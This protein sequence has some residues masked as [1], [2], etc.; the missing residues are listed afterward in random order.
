MMD[1]SQGHEMKKQPVMSKHRTFLAKKK[2]QAWRSA[3]KRQSRQSAA[4]RSIIALP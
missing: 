4:C 2:K 1:T 3:H